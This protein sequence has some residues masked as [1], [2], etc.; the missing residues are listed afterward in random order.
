MAPEREA[1]A[2]VEV[3]A[4]EDGVWRITL[5]RPEKR[6]ALTR[7]MLRAV[8]AAAAEAERA[9]A[10]VVILT[11]E[12]PV[13]SAGADL[14]EMKEGLGHSDVW[15]RVSARIAGLP[16]LTIAALNGTAAGGPLGM[17]LACDL[18]IA[19]E[20][21]EFFYPVLRMGALPQPSDPLRLAAIVGQGRARRMLLGA[22][23]IGAEEALGWGLCD[24]VVAREDLERTVLDMAA[25]ALAA[26]QGLVGGIKR[27]LAG[28]PADRR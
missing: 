4:S 20:G 18:R 23:R 8:E 6:N 7:D 15:E 1:G 24:R 5:A 14:Q 9:A 28:K 11:G 13:F 26:P 17:V 19:A 16:C 10:R 25:P 27:L 2:P 21:A 3:E 22:D 12:G